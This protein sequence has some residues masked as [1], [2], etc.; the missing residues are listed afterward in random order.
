MSTQAGQPAPPTRSPH[1]ARFSRLAALALVIAGVSLLCA[2]LA[3]LGYRWG[4]WP[5]GVA[6]SMLR[7]AA[8]AGIAGLVLGIVAAVRTW[9]AA[10]LRGFW[11]ALLAVAVGLVVAG[12]MYQWLLQAK[13][14]PP[15]HDITTDPADPPAF[16]A[17]LP[18]RQGAANPAEYGGPAVA[19]QQEKAY[20]DIRPLH[21]ALPPARAFQAAL[22]AARDMGW[23][24]DASVPTAGRIEAT[25]T[26]F[27]FGFK[28]DIVVRIRPDSAGSRVD[29]RSVS[30]VGK[31]DVGTNAKRVR[32]YLAR[33]KQ[34]AGT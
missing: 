27:W 25:A 9:T 8:Y 19:A 21:L 12:T 16:V 2:I 4:W 29:V 28:D 23:A 10:T 32:A 31:S 30:R 14:V 11:A 26:T 1:A 3:G 24:I 17:V 7:Y 13:K 5:L 6:F 18:L 20:P 22:T 33:V 15:I 34:A